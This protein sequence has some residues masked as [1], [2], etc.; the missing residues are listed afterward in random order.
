MRA[1]CRSQ[2]GNSPA[3]RQTLLAQAAS[4]WENSRIRSDNSRRSPGFNAGTATPEARRDYALVRLSVIFGKAFVVMPRFSAAN[5]EEIGKALADSAKVQDGDPFAAVTWFQRMARV[6]DGVSRLNATLNYSEALNTGEKLKL[7]IAQL[8][9]VTDDRW[10]G[11]PLKAGKILMGGRLSLAVQSGSPV[12]VRQPLAG[13]L[14]DEWVEVVPSAT[15]TTGIAL[16]YDRPSA[17]PPQ[18]ILIA[19]PPEIELPWTVWSRSKCCWKRSILPE[20]AP[21]IPMRWTKSAITSPRYILLVT[22]PETRLPLTSRRLS[23][24]NHAIYYELD[25]AGT[26]K[27]RRRDERQF[28]GQDLRSAMAA[29]AA[30]AVG[31]VPGRRQRLARSREVASG[32]C[33]A[34]PLSFGASSTNH[35]QRLDL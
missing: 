20:F 12:D 35:D 1:L 24:G 4:I 27:P 5:A 10:V 23:R 30:M 7:T 28:A 16:Q 11:L 13:V 8:P 26:A 19:V 2:C 32:R 3:D 29:G 6:R 22:P 21:L 9:Y 17:A 31:R 34:D 18:T 14:I 15:E 25:A 33:A